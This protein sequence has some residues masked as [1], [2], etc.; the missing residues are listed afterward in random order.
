MR[1]YVASAFCNKSEVRR[2]FGL[3]R[4]AGHIV[5]HDWTVEDAAELPSHQVQEYLEECGI[6]DFR[7]ILSAHC[8]LVLAHPDMKDTRAELGIA[9]GAGIPVVVVEC[10]GAHSVFYGLTSR[11]DSV[12]SAIRWLSDDRSVAA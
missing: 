8:L 12:E 9:L 4:E 5:S 2:V 6:R 3:L 7:G 10:K 1:V 11:F